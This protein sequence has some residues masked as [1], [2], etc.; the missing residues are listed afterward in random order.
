MESL[1]II[2]DLC[3]FFFSLLKIQVGNPEGYCDSKSSGSQAGSIIIFCHPQLMTYMAS[4]WLL[5]LLPHN[6]NLPLGRTSTL[7]LTGQPR[8]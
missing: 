2:R 4:T 7:L 6:H 5:D 1:K 3:I 8:N